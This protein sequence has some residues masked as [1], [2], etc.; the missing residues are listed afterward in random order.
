MSWMES[1]KIKIIENFKSPLQIVLT[2][3][4]P[5]IIISSCWFSVYTVLKKGKKNIYHPHNSLKNIRVKYEGNN[6]V[7]KMSET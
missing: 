6:W 2:L 4:F 3:T 7:R 5:G 1:Y